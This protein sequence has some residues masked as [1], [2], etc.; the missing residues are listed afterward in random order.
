MLIIP[1]HIIPCVLPTPTY[2]PLVSCLPFSCFL[3]FV[4]LR[5]TSPR[6]MVLPQVVS[7]HCTHLPL[8]WLDVDRAVEVQYCITILFFPTRVSTLFF[9]SLES[10]CIYAAFYFI[11]FFLFLLTRRL[12]LI[13]L[14]FFFPCLVRAG[15]SCGYLYHMS[16][17]QFIVPCAYI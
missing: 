9:C 8:I 6:I 2:R 12:S 3:S 16:N 14:A 13:P 15:D 17:V 11:L 10:L 5:P 1:Y 4:L 7:W